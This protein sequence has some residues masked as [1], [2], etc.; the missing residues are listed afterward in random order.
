[1]QRAQTGRPSWHRRTL[2]DLVD[3]RGITYGVV[4]PGPAHTDGTP[5][6]RVN[7]FT[8][9]G[10]QLDDVMRIDPTVAARYSRSRLAGG[11]VL[12]TLVGSV[13]QVAIA[14]PDVK[15]WNVARA[16]GVVP[17]REETPARW[18]AWCLQTPEARQY[19]EARLNTTVQKTLNLRD[20]AALQIPIP[21]DAAVSAISSVLGAL[22]DKIDSDRRLALLLAET[23][24]ALFRARFVDFV[25][26][27]DFEESDIGPIPRGWTTGSITSLA[28]FINGKAFTK[29]A[30]TMGRPILRI[31]ELN[32]GLRDDTLRS[33]VTVTEEHLA[34]N[35]DILFAWSGSLAV[36]KWS[37]PESLINQHIFKVIPEGYPSWFVYQWVHQHMPEFQAIARD[38]ATT[39]GH[40]QRRHLSE[41]RVALPDADT[42]AGIN[43]LLE[44]LDRWQGTL[45]SEI[46]SLAATRD[47]LLPKLISG[48][49]RV[50]DSLDSEEVIGPAVEQ[51]A[52]A[53]P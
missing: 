4:Q 27:E 33:D 51:L 35:H 22:D 48:E 23:A 13:G 2:K 30:N 53:K 28:R 21:P 40:I 46:A 15:G 47:A 16:V 44:P 17:V 18:I 31:K 5:I 41:A 36:Y 42:L 1:V 43:E 11:E 26:V 45:A 50:P 6:V 37:G 32:A 34:R 3:E 12:I 49:I 20:L 7:N 52:G 29:D 8:A 24:A 25:G 14:P 9:A 39:M 19:L 10:L 38:K